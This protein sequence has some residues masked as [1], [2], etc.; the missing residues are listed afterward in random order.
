VLGPDD[1]VTNQ[2]SNRLTFVIVPASGLFSGV[3]TPP[4]GGR[5]L[6]FKGAL[7]QKQT[8]GRGFFLGTNHSG[9]V[10]LTARGS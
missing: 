4:D 5:S 7:L 9:R 2:S 3:V 8:A 10:T 6:S 1:K